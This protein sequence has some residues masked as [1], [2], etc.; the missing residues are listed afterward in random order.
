MVIHGIFRKA[1]RQSPWLAAVSL[2]ALYLAGIGHMAF[3]PH[4]LCEQGEM[5]HA[6]RLDLANLAERVF[7]SP[8]SACGRYATGR[9]GVARGASALPRLY[10]PPQPVVTVARLVRAMQNRDWPAP[11]RIG[12]DR[13]SA[14][15]GVAAC[16]QAFSSCVVA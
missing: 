3:V 13:S 5:T 15:T 9:A 2:L 14:F 11:T 10:E 8:L 7:D 16:P 6:R 1:A 4:V 12:R